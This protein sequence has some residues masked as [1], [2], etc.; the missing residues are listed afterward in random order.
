[1]WSRVWTEVEGIRYRVK[2][3]V[4]GLGY[5]GTGLRFQSEV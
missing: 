2:G 4:K 5:M 3:L 1:M